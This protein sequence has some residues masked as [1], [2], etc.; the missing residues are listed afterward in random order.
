MRH[1]DLLCHCYCVLISDYSLM[2]M[3]HLLSAD[4]QIVSA[5]YFGLDLA[6]GYTMTT[7]GMKP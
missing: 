5:E 1:F 6:F 7:G 3:H 4:V 2:S